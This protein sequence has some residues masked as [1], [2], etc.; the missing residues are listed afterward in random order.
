MSD[1]KTIN[2]GNL[3]IAVV[4]WEV[5]LGRYFAVYLVTKALSND[6]EAEDILNALGVT[7]FY[8]N[9][10]QVWPVLPNNPGPQGGGPKG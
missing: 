4:D 5:Q 9:D 7:L 10:V 3:T 6:N 8:D 1:K 2:I